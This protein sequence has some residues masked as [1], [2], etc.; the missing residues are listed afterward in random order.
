MIAYA[1][2]ALGMRVNLITNGTLI[3][4]R[5]ARQLKEA[6][7]ASA[8]VS[9]EADRADVHD[10]ITGVPGSLDASVTGLVALR[11]AGVHVHPHATVCTI[12]REAVERLPAFA[13]SLGVDRFSLRHG[14][15]RRPG[16]GA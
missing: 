10:E 6:G 7:L 8:Q 9:I 14:D 2:D 1:H 15:S 12:N 11:E 4:A 16:C 13:R 5:A 3:D